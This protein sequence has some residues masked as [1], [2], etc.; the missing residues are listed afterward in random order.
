LQLRE[1]RPFTQ[2][3]LA[4][5][6]RVSR[7]T[8]ARLEM[9]DREPSPALRERLARALEVSVAELTGGPMDRYRYQHTAMREAVSILTS[10]TMSPVE[11]MVGAMETIRTGF[12]HHQPPDEAKESYRAVRRRIEGDGSFEAR[13]R[14]M[15]AEEMNAFKNA[16]LNLEGH[17][18]SAYHEAMAR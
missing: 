14:R 1:S 9:G 18:A 15:T 4:K 3:A 13:A 10:F 17:L 12:L 5:K 6:V 7:N 2:A 8:I 16:V 11:R